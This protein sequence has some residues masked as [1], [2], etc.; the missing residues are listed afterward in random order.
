MESNNLNILGQLPELEG[1]ELPKPLTLDEITE[2][3][4]RDGFD[5]TKK[6]EN[7]FFCD[8]I[9]LKSNLDQ[10]NINVVN[11]I[12]QKVLFAIDEIQDE[13]FQ[14]VGL[15][16]A[17]FLRSLDFG[18]VNKVYPEEVNE[19]F[20]KKY[21]Q[22]LLIRIYFRFTT[23]LCPAGKRMMENARLNIKKIICSNFKMNYSDFAVSCLH[24]GTKW[25]RQDAQD[26]YFYEYLEKA[27]QEL[28]I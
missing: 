17:G 23:D 24:G 10:K 16:G 15:V 3:R 22:K 4:L 12:I 8:G 9:Y 19:F 18:Y 14:G 25:K 27:E 7:S 5:I 13:H 11:K 6:I 21:D 26:E 2:L 1:E 28:L 20:L